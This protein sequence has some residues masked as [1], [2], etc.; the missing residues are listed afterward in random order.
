MRAVEEAQVRFDG[1]W[2][3]L[4]R[5][6][7][8][9]GVRLIG[10]L[11]LFVARDSADVWSH[12][13]LF[14]FDS[15]AGVPPDA[16]AEDGQL[17]GNPQYAW[18]A[19]RRSRFRWWVARFAR[20]FE[21]VDTVRIDHFLGLHRAWEVSARARSARRGTWTPV[22]GEALLHAVRKEVGK[23]P[24]IAENLGIIT[25]EAEALRR[26]FG[27]PGMHVLQF[28]FGDDAM[29]RPFWFPPDSVVY[30]GTHDNDTL[31]GWQAD[32][33]G[34]GGRA[35]RYLGCDKA[36]LPEAMLRLAWLSASNLAIAPVQDVLGLGSAAR[37]NVP[38][39]AD[40][41]WGW[42]LRRGQLTDSHARRLR[43]L[44]ADAA[45]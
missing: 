34:D 29:A 24:M 45:R 12:R 43:A 4:R 20:M 11:P 44:T 23:R 14:R 38:G 33:N 16:F 13:S 26:R 40:G 7:A 8:D 25:E 21:L 9:A 30:T 28:C 3:A 35:L 42:R 32:A 22:P 17:W 10:D 27:I 39:V 15:V 1:A 2:M 6:C 19:H 5:R 41:N 37:M 18:P 36:G 31:R